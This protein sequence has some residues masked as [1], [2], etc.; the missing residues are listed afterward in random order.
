MIVNDVPPA[1]ICI[2]NIGGTQTTAEIKPGPDNSPFMKLGTGQWYS[3]QFERTNDIYMF[4]VGN[5][6]SVFSIG[7]GKNASAWSFVQAN[8]QKSTGPASCI[9]GD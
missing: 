5:G 6:D 1:I 4:H 2:I 8:G 9:V 7:L 3:A